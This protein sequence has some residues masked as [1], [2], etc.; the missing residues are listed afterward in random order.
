MTLENTQVM[1]I[2]CTNV[3]QDTQRKIQELQEVVS[4]CESTIKAMKAKTLEEETPRF[5]RWKPKEDEIFYYIEI[6]GLV[7]TEVWDTFDG[8]CWKLYESWNCFS[9][10]EAAQKESNRRQARTK[11]EWLSKQLRALIPHSYDTGYYFIDYDDDR[12]KRKGF[13]VANEL[14][15]WLGIAMFH[16]REDAEYALAQM[17]DEE[18][19][20]LKL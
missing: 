19:E 20:A 7:A 13:Y 6:T 10:A 2:S 16:S 9:S 12:K 1:L 17:T 15:L 14:C 11:L 4:N 8:T 3:L 18:L 5:E